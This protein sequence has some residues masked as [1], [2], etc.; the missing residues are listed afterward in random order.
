MLLNR[1]P[2]YISLRTSERHLVLVFRRPARPR[3]R[4]G[5]P[6]RVTAAAALLTVALAIEHLH[7]AGDDLG[8]VAFLP[9]LLVLP[10]VGAI[11][12][13]DVDQRAL[14][15]VLPADLRQAGPGDDVVPLGALLLLAAL[16][17]EFLVGGHGELG[18]GLSTG[19]GTN[20]GVLSK[21]PYENDFVD[22]V[23]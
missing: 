1:S 11:G 15:Q 12:S 14:A 6:A 17:G 8:A 2:S 19:G 5:R 10:A 21:A 4:G 23:L 18:H 3:R 13:F 22:H 9:G 16:V 20:L 7:L